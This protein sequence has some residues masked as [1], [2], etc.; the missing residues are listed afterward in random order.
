MKRKKTR[1]K[2]SEHTLLIRR[3]MK[4]KKKSNWSHQ[5]GTRVWKP[6]SAIDQTLRKRKRSTIVHTRMKLTPRT[7]RMKKTIRRVSPVMIALSHLK[8][9]LRS[10]RKDQDCPSLSR[11]KTLNWMKFWLSPM[12]STTTQSVRTWRNAAHLC[13]KDLH[14]SNAS[15]CSLFK[16]LFQSSS[17][18]VTNK[19]LLTQTEIQLRSVL[20]AP[21]SFTLWF[22]LRSNSL[23]VC[24]DT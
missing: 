1:S 9:T 21:F 16:C 22:M 6:S 15:L 24:S 7:E 10:S 3:R 13:N 23:W 5:C 2:N 18:G 12:M 20:F 11:R 17:S 14:L 4:E 19:K 8:K